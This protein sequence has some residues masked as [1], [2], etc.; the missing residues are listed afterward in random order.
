MR[1]SRATPQ[2]RLDLLPGDRASAR[3]LLKNTGPDDVMLHEKGP[4]LSVLSGRRVYTNRHLPGP[5]PAGCPEL[6]YALFLRPLDDEQRIAAVTGPPV[7]I[8]VRATG[9]TVRVYRLRDQ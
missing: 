1:F 3:W 7:T 6:D 9:D 8:P 4:I 5:W 2:W